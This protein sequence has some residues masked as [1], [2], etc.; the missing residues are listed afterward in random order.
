M[1]ALEKAGQLRKLTWPL[2]HGVRKA[3]CCT[4]MMVQW[5]RVGLL[6]SS[7]FPLITYD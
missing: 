6:M 3:T 4:E 7:D 2:S 1:L 5:H